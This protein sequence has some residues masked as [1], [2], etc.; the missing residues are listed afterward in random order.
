ML[1]SLLNKITEE[2]PNYRASVVK[3]I[4]L[5]SLCMLHQESICLHK[6]S[7]V[8][9]L[10]LG[11]HQSKHSAHVKRFYR[12]LSVYAFSRLW[13]DLLYYAFSLLRLESKYLVLDGT[14][15]FARSKGTHYHHYLTL[16]VVYQG[17]A[18]PILWIDLRKQGLSNQKQ[19]IMLLKKAKKRFQLEG[20]ILLADREYIGK[21][22]FKFLIE[23]K[24]DFVIR[25]RSKNYKEE[26]SAASGKSYDRLV[27]KVLNSKK[28]SK[29]VGKIFEMEGMTL[30]L[31]IA[32]NP[33][34]EAKD[35]LVYLITNLLEHPIKVA[36]KYPIRWQIE[37]CFKHLKSNG[38]DLEKMNVEGYARQQL[39]MAIMIFAYTVSLIEGLKNYKKVPRKKYRNGKC[40]KVIS[41]FRKGL[42]EVT[43]VCW[44]FEAFCQYLIQNNQQAKNKYRSLKT[45]IV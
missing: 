26:V 15:W 41:V 5:L 45:I 20:K 21:H 40:Y 38:F 27:N 30:Q 29:V 25:V 16:S 33:H 44:N 24:I 3:N 18:I 11:N 36:S 13:L 14:S 12:L 31:V 19:R 32:K 7:K 22:W 23:N 9:G 42:A 10:F 43:R 34:P 39:L 4:L 2:F 1:D 8:V 17:V 6:I 37:M 28:P 35:H